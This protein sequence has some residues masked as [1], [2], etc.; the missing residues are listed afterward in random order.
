M[1]AD[2]NL[3][4]RTSH[5][6]LERGQLGSV[7][8]GRS[9]IGVLIVLFA[10]AFCV[11]MVVATWMGLGRMPE[12]DAGGHYLEAGE[13]IEGNGFR[14]VL[15]NGHSCPSASRM[16]MTSLLLALAMRLFGATPIVARVT[17]ISFASL[18]APLLCLTAR[19]IMPRRW[20]VLSG[21][22]A[23]VHPTFVYYSSDT[24]TEA[25]YIPALLVATLFSVWA[26][27][28]PR[29]A[30]ALT[31]GLTWGLAALC[32]P[33]AVP[34]AIL[35]A[36]GLGVVTRSWRS[37]LTL[38]LGT[39]LALTPWWV[40]N[41][42]VFGKPVLLSLEGGETFLGANNPYVAANPQL[43]GIWIPPMSKPEYRARLIRCE[44]QVEVNRM[45]M[46][47]G[48][49]YLKSNPQVVPGLVLKKWA[50]WL[51][52]VTAAG[53]LIRLAVLCSYGVLLGLV[54]LGAASGKIRYAP[55]LVPTLAITLADLVV[56]G[57]YWGNLTRGR[58]PL[59]LIWIPWGVQSFRLLLGGPLEAWWRRAFPAHAGRSEP[60][61][62]G[63]SR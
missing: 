48:I 39:M 8:K 1:I 58:I 63:G 59:E 2:A 46:E 4:D 54:I 41:A 42:A 18:S 62:V 15:P 16:P 9:K 10:M 49:D 45:M 30:T 23:A 53:G 37:S 14:N 32:R 28:K 17:A 61:F 19:T 27:T 36:L 35:M 47:I 11:R 26:I 29:F 21:V 51:T 55:L 6:S 34:A 3:R 20:A 22:G 43:A 31:A 13:L 56:V 60:A 40:R 33:H 5:D 12:S 24:L 25:F 7:I 44:S 50:R 52:P 38:V 57:V